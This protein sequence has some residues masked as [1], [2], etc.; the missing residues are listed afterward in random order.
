MSCLNELRASDRRQE[1]ADRFARNPTRLHTRL[2][3]SSGQR[4]GIPARV[5]RISSA[6][7]GIA[8]CCQQISWAHFLN[9]KMAERENDSVAVSDWH[10]ALKT[11]PTNV[12]ANA[13]LGNWMLQTGGDLKLAV[14]YFHTAIQS[15]RARSFVR[16]LQLGG[17]LDQELPGARAE[18]MR[19]A[20][21]MRRGGEELD[22]GLKHRVAEWCFDPIVNEHEEMIETLSALSENDTWQTYLWLEDGFRSGPDRALDREFIHANLLEVSGE[23]DDALWEY[24]VLKGNLR[25]R[26]GSLPSQVEAAISR[27]SQRSQSR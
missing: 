16:R 12:Y 7:I 18:L 13:M 23:R 25:G 1:E 8:S 5:L 9:H 19:G 22:P 21:E 20:D 6:I 3:R 10:L 15:G 17:L 11:G 27:L 26:Q 2:N 24:A 4:P 14:S